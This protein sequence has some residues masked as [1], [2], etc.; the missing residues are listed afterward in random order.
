MASL[1]ILDFTIKKLFPKMFKVAT[2]NVEVII[3]GS[4]KIY[5]EH[6][7]LSVE[8]ATYSFAAMSVASA[9]E[10]P[11]LM[12]LTAGVILTGIPITYIVPVYR[13]YHDYYNYQ[14]KIID[15]DRGPP[16]QSQF[17]KPNLYKK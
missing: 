7:L 12:G 14:L 10:S 8:L 1:K 2:S 13:S 5:I 4:S 6:K 16:P 17:I 11:T 15:Y 3:G 9:T